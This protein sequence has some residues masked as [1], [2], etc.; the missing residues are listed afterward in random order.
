LY[1]L[2]PI[3]HTPFLEESL[4]LTPEQVLLASPVWMPR[5]RQGKLYALVGADESAE[6]LR[7][8]GLM[9][10]AWGKTTV[11]VCEAIPE[12]NHFSVLEDL[13]APWTRLHAVA[14]ELMLS[15]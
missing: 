3:M 8:N 6:F 1:D 9:Q 10:T 4:R 15:V 14:S 11:P 2:E 7:H 12:R 13:A 5:P